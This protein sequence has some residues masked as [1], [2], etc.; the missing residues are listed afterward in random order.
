MD[1]MCLMCE[2]VKAASEEGLCT[3]CGFVVQHVKSIGYAII[4]TRAAGVGCESCL[5]ADVCVGK[6]YADQ[7]G[8]IISVCASR[9]EA[10]TEKTE[11]VDQQPDVERRVL[12]RCKSECPHSADGKEVTQCIPASFSQRIS[13]CGQVGK[14]ARESEAIR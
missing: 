6:M 10:A 11:A 2:S 9:F 13:Y 1:D 5:K 12:E 4:P 14:W 3:S 8:A 7:V